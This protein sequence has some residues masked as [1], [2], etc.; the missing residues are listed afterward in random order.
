MSAGP[1]VTLFGRR[2]SRLRRVFRVQRLLRR[3]YLRQRAFAVV[4][5]PDMA[6]CSVLGRFK[7]FVD[8]QDR[9]IAPHLMVDGIWEPRL[10]EWLVDELV[11][12]TV[13]IDVGANVGYF[14]VLMAALGARV[15][16]VEPNP[17]MVRRIEAAR[18]A[19]GL[20]DAITVLPVPVAD[21][22]GRAVVLEVEA[23]HPGGAQLQDAPDPAAATLRTRRLDGL[24]G[25]LDAALVKIDAEGHEDRIWQGMAG[26]L[27]GP[28]L[29]TVVM[30]FSGP[31]YRDAPGFL[32]AIE[33][34][35]F[36]LAH[37]DNA[38]GLQPIAREAVLDPSVAW[39]TLVLR[40]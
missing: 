6:L 29:R 19:N 38:R 35:G 37:L 10:T 13:A 21:T 14:S 32:D 8:P 34:V 11:P 2:R 23:D 9:S 16:A 36:S 18:A 22:D 5:A 28:A 1:S 30:E 20:C 7:L 17:A 24:P 25:A 3:R 39:R 4:L 40:R 33:A 15:L 12:G 27:A 31:V 26:M